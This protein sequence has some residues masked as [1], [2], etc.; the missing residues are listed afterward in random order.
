MGGGEGLNEKSY[1]QN[2]LLFQLDG[3]NKG[4]DST[5]WSDL[6]GDISFPYNEHVTILENGIYF[7]GTV[8]TVMD[9]G[10]AAS[11]RTFVADNCTIEACFSTPSNKSCLLF[12]V[13]SVNG[14]QFGFTSANVYFQKR[15]RPYNSNSIIEGNKTVSLSPIIGVENNKVLTE[16]EGTGW[17]GAGNIAVGGRAGGGIYPFTGVIYSVR[18]YNRSLTQ[19]E[20]FHNQQIDNQRFN[21]GIEL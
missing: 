9:S 12:I 5:A 11:G 6:V 20:V 10:R 18:V 15:E 13:P 14:V 4:E 21:L 2:G 1:I 17:G 8:G 7:D 19:Q 3:I 16:G